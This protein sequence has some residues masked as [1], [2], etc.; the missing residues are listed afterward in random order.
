MYSDL[1]IGFDGSV[2]S[3]D[4]VALGRRLARATGARPTVIYVRSPKPLTPEILEVAEDY[5]WGA[6]VA[7]T[8]DEARAMLRGPPVRGSLLGPRASRPRGGQ[9]T[10]DAGSDG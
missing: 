6:S 5:S 10:L 8:L 9:G 7:S 2:A 1:I 4:A 3:R